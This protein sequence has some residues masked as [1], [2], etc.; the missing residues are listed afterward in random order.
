MQAVQFTYLKLLALSLFKKRRVFNIEV[1][2]APRVMCGHAG[3]GMDQSTTSAVCPSLKRKPNLERSKTITM[4]TINPFRDFLPP[5]LFKI[6]S[7]VPELIGTLCIGIG[8]GKGTGVEVGAADKNTGWALVVGC[9]AL[10]ALSCK[11]AE[12]N[13]C[14][15]PVA[16]WSELEKIG[17][18][19][20]MPG[21][22][23]PVLFDPKFLYGSS[24]LFILP[25][26]QS[27]ARLDKSSD[28]GLACRDMASYQKRE[29]SDALTSHLVCSLPIYCIFWIIGQ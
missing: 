24:M 29:K 13:G 20:K 28:C 27:Q 9:C 1:F 21:A 4:P 22:G 15:P 18:L 19:P 11:P 6:I 8:V 17:W 14:V 7:P 26:P 10:V 5:P 12:V 23:P 3:S 2:T 25:Q 16:G